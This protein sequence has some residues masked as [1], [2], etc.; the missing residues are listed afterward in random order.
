MRRAG[1]VGGLVVVVLAAGIGLVWVRRDRS[2]GPPH[3]KAWDA[4][5]LPL[6]Q[7]VEEARGL[8]FH[9]PVAVEYLSD[10]DFRRAVADEP[11]GSPQKQRDDEAVDRA[12]GLP[13]GNSG[14]VAAGNALSGEGITAYYDDETGKV[15]V[16]GTELTVGRRATIVHELTHALQD[17]HFDLARLGADRSDD[18]NAAFEAVVEGDAVRTEYAYVDSLPKADQDAYDKEQ[19]AG[20]A[21]STGIADVPDWLSAET[22][23]PYSV[24]EAFTEVLAAH[25][26]EE[27]VDG[28]LRTPPPAVADA[29]DPERYRRGDQPLAV[30][31]PAAPAG[32]RVAKRNVFGELRWLLVLAERVPAAD[33]LRAADGWGGDAYLAYE[34]QGRVCVKAEVAG[35]R[36]AATDELARALGRWA[37]AM[38]A[39]AGATAGRRGDVVEVASCD[40]GEAGLPGSS[41]RGSQVDEA[42]RL[43]DDRA[44][45]AADKAAGG[46]AADVDPRL[47]RGGG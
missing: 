34:H 27:A 10:A 45:A 46:S 23:F 12:L 5:V 32:D 25:G 36:P 6:V 39:P 47:R 4:Q 41:V 21:Y 19:A 35:L 44:N 2:S 31:A 29:M 30:A 42:V 15:D 37:K 28:A 13:L 33:A 22:D 40:P 26:G 38:P 14:L 43:L 16:R 18:R 1:L 7:F 8:R 9:H 20:D 17:Q 3:P 11:A 24:G